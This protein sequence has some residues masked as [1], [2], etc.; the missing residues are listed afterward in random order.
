MCYSAESIEL[1]EYD[2]ITGVS[3][4]NQDF[5]YL[6]EYHGKHLSI[7][8]S[9]NSYILKSKAYVG[10]I[11]LKDKIINIRT[12]VQIANLYY[13]LTYAYNLGKFHEFEDNDEIKNLTPYELLV[14]IL[15]KW[16]EHSIKKGLYRSYE[17]KTELLSGVKGKII[18]GNFGKHKGKTTCK[19]HELTYSIPENRILKGTLFHLIKQPLPDDLRQKCIRYIR[20]MGDIQNLELSKRVFSQISYNRLNYNYMKIIELCRLIFESSFLDTLENNVVFSSYMVNMNRLFELFLA[21]RIKENFKNVSAPGR[22]DNWAQGNTS[23]L[24]SIFPDILIKDR[25]II[26]AKYYKNVLNERGKLHSHNLYQILCYMSVI[27]LD[28]VL[29]YPEQDRHFE[30]RFL[31]NDKC[32]WILTIPLYGSLE[33][34][35]SGVESVISKIG[36][37][38]RQSESSA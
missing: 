36:D 17:S 26:D 28:G 18:V 31:F 15:L 20:I 25:L 38:I 19:Y 34:M 11:K 30:E 23:I 12:K 10:K 16:I 32:F 9:G 29:I 2:T 3:L 5:R 7:E 22:R 14:T 27:N 37:V 33:K 13:M 4:S 24:P 21:N 1:S 6:T 35:I 8:K